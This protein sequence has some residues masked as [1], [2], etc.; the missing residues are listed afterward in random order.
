MREPKK[1]KKKKTDGRREPERRE[2]R[3]GEEGVKEAENVV[4]R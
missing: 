1:K 3:I 2:I 4:G